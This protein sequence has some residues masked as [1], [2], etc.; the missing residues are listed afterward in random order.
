MRTKITRT[1]GCQC[2]QRQCAFVDIRHHLAV[3]KAIELFQLLF[4]RDAACNRTLDENSD[5]PF[6]PCL[7]NQPVRLGTLHAQNLRHF[8]LGFP[9]S[10]MQPS[11]TGCQ[12][13]F[14]VHVHG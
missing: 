10:K 7:G 13:G 14:L 3:T 4:E 11:R 12:C 2:A 6:S 1:R 8:A 9:T 5:Q